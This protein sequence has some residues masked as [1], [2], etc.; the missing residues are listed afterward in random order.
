[1]PNHSKEEFTGFSLLG[2][3]I[4]YCFCLLNICLPVKHHKQLKIEFRTFYLGNI[5]QN[6]IFNHLGKL[7]FNVIPP[8]V[9]SLHFKPPGT[10][11]C[12]GIF[13]GGVLLASPII[14][15]KNEFLLKIQQVFEEAS[16]HVSF[17][18]I[19]HEAFLSLCHQFFSFP[20]QSMV[21]F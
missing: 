10:H 15:K 9:R 17:S 16:C 4:Y 11:V 18:D 21:N 8:R 3:N 20:C 13:F 12:K 19:T 7:Y 6:F 14:E 1:M 5:A 2:I